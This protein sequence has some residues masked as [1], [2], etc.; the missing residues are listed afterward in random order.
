[1]RVGTI[2]KYALIPPE[3][4]VMIMYDKKIGRDIAMN[5]QFEEIVPFGRI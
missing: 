2:G 3:K 4:F 5:G 1:M